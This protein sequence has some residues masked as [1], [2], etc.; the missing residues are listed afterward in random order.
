MTYFLYGATLAFTWFL[1]LNVTLSLLVAAIARHASARLVP[2]AP[3]VR[4]RVL[5][6]LRLIPS[7]ASIVFVVVVFLPS[8]LELEPRDFDE[9]FGVMTTA[10]AL[11]SCALLSAAVWRGAAALHD[12]VKRSRSWIA[13][14]RPIALA[15]S[16]VPAFCLDAPTPV[17][18]LVGVFRPKL[19]VT[20][21]LLEVLTPEELRAAISHEVGHLG[22]WDNLKRLAMRATPDALSALGPSRK[23]EHDWALA[24]EHA[25]DA[26][27][28][29]NPAT[30]LALASALLKIARL[31]PPI[32][33]EPALVS[34]LVGGDAIVSRIVRLMEGSAENRPSLG[35]RIAALAALASVLVTLVATYLPLLA[36]VHQVSEVLVRVLP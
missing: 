12:A 1:A 4:A 11:L 23:L 15:G 13:R 34:P 7:I 31:T 19:L 16:P 3:D 10:F 20:R 33:S 18:T 17:M 14:A 35:R 2:S 24:A 26:R 36:T 29:H 28:A 22:S 6:T 27:A 9:A 8:F 25:A 30:G 21:S 32:A 5:L